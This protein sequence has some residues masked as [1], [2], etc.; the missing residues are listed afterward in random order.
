MKRIILKPGEERR[1]LAG[2]PWVYGNEV[3]VIRETG[4][5]K[6]KET[7][8]TAGECSDIE[9]LRQGKALYLGRA[10]VNPASQIIARIYSRSK[11]GLDKGF[12]KRRIREAMELRQK[13]GYDLSK[14]SARIVFGEADGLPGLIIDRFVGRPYTGRPIEESVK[15]E[16]FSWLVIQ[17]LAYGMDCRREMIFQALEEIFGRSADIVPLAGIAE[18]SAPV[19]ELEG[20]PLVDK[21]ISGDFPPEGI[22]ITE[23]GL[24]FMVNL[25]GGQK[26]GHFLDQKNNKRITGK[27]ASGLAEKS[28]VSFRVLDCFCYTGGFGITAGRAAADALAEYRTGA[29]EGAVIITAVDASAAAL[30]LAQKNAFLN[31]I[32]LQTIEA[33]AFDFLHH[34]ERRKEKYNLIILDPPA[35]AKNRSALENALRG[36]KEINLRALKLLEKGGILV[37]CS[38]S[39]AVNEETFKRMI[40]GAA[41]DAGRR[42]VQLD[43]RYQPPDHPILVGY[44]E[45]LYLKCGFY[46]TM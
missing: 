39:H 6:N 7:N 27:Y 40:A 41:A 1:I 9:G 10:I 18:K 17:F 3:A 8:L 12:F 31:G 28:P 22:V 29:G 26:T 20:L 21:V 11:E 2:H 32:T 5:E 13:A 44:D 4:K 38:C 43:F 36:Y 23:N 45:S 35:F 25:P 14:D 16:P 19:R 15:E 37:S 33:D 42:L 34:A 24:S 46:R 30:D